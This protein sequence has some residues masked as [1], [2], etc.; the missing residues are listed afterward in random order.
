MNKQLQKFGE[1]IQINASNLVAAQNVWMDPAI[2]DQFSKV[3]KEL[4]RIA[5]KAN[6]FLYFTATIITAAEAAI[7][8]RDGSLKKDAT[9]RDLNCNWEKKGRSWKWVCSDSAVKPYKNNNGDI[10]PEEELIKAHKK[11][12]GR[13]LCL[14]HKSTSV[15]MVRGIIVD[16]YYDY[17]NKKVIALC[18]LDK[19]NYP[20]LARKV[21]TG[22]CTS[23]SMG[24]AVAEAICTDC[25]TVAMAEPDF[26]DCMRH[27]RCYGEINVGL[28]PIELSIVVTGADPDAK[29]RQVLASAHQIGEQIERYSTMKRTALDETADIESSTKI[30]QG[31]GKIIED[32][33]GLKDEIKSLKEREQEEQKVHE[34]AE[35]KEKEP[36]AE[37]E[38][39]STD[40]GSNQNLKT[41]VDQLSAQYHT[42][43]ERVS[44]LQ[45]QYEESKMTIKNAY[46][47]GGGGVNEPTPGKPK[48]PAEDAEGVRNTQDKQMTGQMDTGPVDGMHPGYQGGE[49][50]ESLKKR[51]LRAEQEQRSIRRQAA[52]EK[53]RSNQGGL[54]SNNYFQGGGG[55]NEPSPG[56]PKYPAEDAEGV[57][58]KE[59]KQMVGQAPFPGVGDVDG[60]HPSPASADEKN[61]LK[62]KQMLARATKLKAE[63]RK[64]S[65]ADGTD[66]LKNSRWDVLANGKL[67]LTATVADFVGADKVEM[68]YDSVVTAKFGENLMRK[69]RED[70]G[71]EKI[72]A[73]LKG[74]Q[75]KVAQMSEAAPAPAPAPMMPAGEPEMTPDAG[76]T[77]DPAEQIPDLLEKAENV[78]ADLRQGFEAL[79]DKSGNEL[80]GLQSMSPESLPPSMA[81][82]LK[83][84]KTMTKTLVAGFSKAAKEI[85]TLATELKT[86]KAVYAAKTL[87]K[88][89]KAHVDGLVREAFAD[90][91]VALAESDKLTRSFINYTN[92]TETLTK[93]AK[94]HLT[95]MKTAQSHDPLEGLDSRYGDPAGAG[96]A[97]QA[98]KPQAVV[99][100]KPAA[101]AAKPG[102][103]LTDKEKFEQMTPEQRN[104][105]ITR[106]EKARGDRS[107]LESNLINVTRESPLTHQG[108]AA[109]APRPSGQNQSAEDGEVKDEA[110][111][112][113]DLKM[114]PDGALEGSPKEVG[115]AM[116]AKEAQFDLKTKEGR[117][118]WRDSLSKAAQKGVTFS[119]MLG[120]AHG[121]GGMTTQLDVKP[122]G[123]L[124]KVE[125][126]EEA[127]KVMY[128]IAT[129]PVKVRKEA[130]EIHRLIVA[131]EID[132]SQFDALIA[133]GLDKDA[134]SY[135]KGFYGEAKDG[136]SQ[137][138]ADLV[139]ERNAKK[140]AEAKEEYQVKLA[141][142]YELTYEMIRKGQLNDNRPAINQQVKEIM[143][144]NDAGFTSMASWVERQPGQ[145]KVASGPQVPQ[146]G[147]M[148]VPQYLAPQVSDLSSELDSYFANSRPA[149]RF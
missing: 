149:T 24:T 114:A 82:N 18:A 141:R 20:D 37:S 127:H 128:D 22:Y 138:A 107:E 131:G 52:I 84:H 91:Q 46:H 16:T 104:A 93:K 110:K 96:S 113:N 26:C 86:A 11:W 89:D 53:A 8:N 108:P 33:N 77:G 17:V 74:S 148:G 120:K 143:A 73:Q 142:A 29:I 98:P 12:V 59:D 57:R 61:E 10:F 75:V 38:R 103:I 106:L 116:K 78:M 21:S 43:F 117:A 55:V 56:K 136:G 126:L 60:L 133:N 41:A 79:T 6:D 111:D 7:L 105:E 5:P 65:H 130:E 2:V 134:V 80:E 124:A 30:E 109:Q 35:A 19:V 76:G 118:Q 137:F 45:K 140:A 125:T 67:I 102:G 50:D 51:L 88:K 119:D 115:E 54:I 15:D 27:R 31:L 62:R 94:Q 146:V 58:N 3:A 47:Q 64:A 95:N 39:S 121:K 34:Q 139:K 70:G 90:L 48:Y 132:P 32:L 63:F 123:D 135:W 145:V 71:V 23:V 1:A 85:N 87:S 69:I 42:L 147:M 66:D 83:H 44:Q 92:A 4:K 122:S 72:S 9:G 129:A 28:S 36:A 81:S 25:G 97:Y 49:S 100:A 101:P 14:D 112:E 13:P 144:M 40:D 68:L 99:P